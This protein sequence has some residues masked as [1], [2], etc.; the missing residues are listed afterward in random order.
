MG[1]V[2]VGISLFCIAKGILLCYTNYV[3]QFWMVPADILRGIAYVRRFIPPV[4]ELCR[5]GP[6]LRFPGAWFRLRTFLFYV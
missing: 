4:W 6:G 1:G 3:K 2:I 5:N